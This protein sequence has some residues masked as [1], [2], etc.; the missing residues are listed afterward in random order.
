[1]ETVHADLDHIHAN[2][3]A[4]SAEVK[5]LKLALAL[6]R[7]ERE[8]KYNPNWPSQPWVPAGNRDGGQW[9]S[10]GGGGGGDPRRP[11]SPPAPRRAP[12]PAERVFWR[13]IGWTAARLREAERDARARAEHEV[14]GGL[15]AAMRV[16]DELTRLIFRVGGEEG[17]RAYQR[18]TEMV[19]EG[20]AEAG[21]AWQGF[22]NRQIARGTLTRQQADDLTYLAGR[23]AIAAS[24]VGP[25][26]R[27]AR[28]ARSARAVI[29]MTDRRF[30]FPRTQPSGLRGGGNL[31]GEPEAPH[32]NDN[33]ITRTSLRRQHDAAVHFDRAG[34]QV[35]EQPKLTSEERRLAGLKEDANPDMLIENRV[36]DVVSPTTHI[37]TAYS[38]IWDKVREGQAYRIA[39]SLDGISGTRAELQRALR[40]NPIPG[41]QEVLTIDR[42]GRI[43][44][45]YP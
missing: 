25:V 9:T 19:A 45:A 1:M 43:G 21:E 44:R 13:T 35:F 27:V 6:R 23:G 42:D 10:G 3:V 37:G 17:Q 33:E 39:V 26:G 16:P 28:T 24:V 32:P 36:F 20:A 8:R 2:L 31:F 22:I 15:D 14:P 5:A 7:R 30:H 12:H 41:L 40:E 29:P 4:V 18:L 34:Y 11:R 38:D